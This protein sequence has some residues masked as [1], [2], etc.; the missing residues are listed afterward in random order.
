M[1]ALTSNTLQPARASGGVLKYML[2][3]LRKATLPSPCATTY[4]TMASMVAGLYQY[5]FRSPFCAR[6]Q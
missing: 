3:V 1:P 5:W 6:Q 2:G 4:A